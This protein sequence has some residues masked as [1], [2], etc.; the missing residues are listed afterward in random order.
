[1]SRRLTAHERALWHRVAA[2]VRPLPG[3]SAPPPAPTPPAPAAAPPAPSPPRPGARPARP[4]PAP[5]VPPVVA[6]TLDGGWDR[7]LR[8]GL[9]TPDRV[10]DLHDHSLDAAHERLM[11]T[12]DLAA[13]TGARLILVVTGKGRPGRPGRIRAE[14]GHWLDHPAVRSRV[15]ALRPAHQRHGGSG[16]FYLVLRR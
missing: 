7:R 10:I 4:A 14:L 3:K 6:A 2:T 5:P 16:A 15:A 8:R 13:A 12:L 1:M 11:M 9:V